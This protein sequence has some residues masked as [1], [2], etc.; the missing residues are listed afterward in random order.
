MREIT[1]VGVDLAKHVIHVH[2]VDAV[3]AM[4]TNRPLP[5]DKFMAWCAQLPPG[6]LLAMEAS[7]S[8]HHWARK[9]VALGLDARIIAAHLVAPYRMQ[10]KSGK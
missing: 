6:C 3:G 4:V 2:A 1:R 10:G 8:A 9:M 5:R 7:S